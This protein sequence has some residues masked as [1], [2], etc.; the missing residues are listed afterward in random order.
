[1]F[2]TEHSIVTNPIAEL[3]MRPRIGAPKSFSG[4][5]QQTG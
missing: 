3:M 4:T 5:G 2:V 1:V